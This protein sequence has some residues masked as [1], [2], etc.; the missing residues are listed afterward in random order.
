MI[1]IFVHK[2]E[3]V[4]TLFL[5]PVKSRDKLTILWFQFYV[6]KLENAMTLFIMPLKNFMR[7]QKEW[8]PVPKAE[9]ISITDLK[10]IVT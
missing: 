3:N 4:M 8:L 9:I 5:M 1:P 2:L 7:T 10:T 6:H